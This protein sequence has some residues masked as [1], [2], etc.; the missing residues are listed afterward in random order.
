MSPVL[1]RINQYQWPVSLPKDISLDHLR[2]ELLDLG[3]EYVWIDVVCLWQQSNIHGLE[4]LRWE[5]WKLDVPTIGSIYRAATHIVRYFNGLGVPFNNSGWDDSRH[6]LQR[7]WTLQEIADEKTTIN[8]GIPQALGHVFLN[9][10]GEFSGR[11]V[12]LRSVMRPVIQ[13][14]TQVDSQRGCKIYEL[15]LGDGQKE[16][17]KPS[18]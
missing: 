4:R 15:V 12:K 2:P 8:G 9:S 17:I 10:L 18:R 13:L 16:S 7:A 3:A 5:E 1:T 11:V 6:W 14:A